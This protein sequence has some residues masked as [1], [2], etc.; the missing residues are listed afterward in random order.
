MRERCNLSL[1]LT[2]GINGL[3]ASYELKKFVR[4]KR[5]SRKRYF[6]IFFIIRFFFEF[7]FLRC[8]SSILYESYFFEM[9][10]FFIISY[11]TM[12]GRCR[13]R[14]L[15]CTN[16]INVLETIGYEMDCKHF[17]ETNE[18]NIIRDA[19]R[20]NGINVLEADF[21]DWKTRFSRKRYFANFLYYIILSYHERNIIREINRDSNRTNGIDGK[22]GKLRADWKNFFSRFERLFGKRGRNLNEGKSGES[23]VVAG[24]GPRA[25]TSDRRMEFQEEEETRVTT[26]FTLRVTRP[27]PFSPLPPTNKYI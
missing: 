9:R 21:T 11:F 5:L 3:E 2:N 8:N 16:R 25:G 15:N 4:G 13:P 6:W 18:R 24:A 14:H 19:N 1:K 7:R 12:R 10:I 23:G 17:R 26:C 20:T 22:R 27:R